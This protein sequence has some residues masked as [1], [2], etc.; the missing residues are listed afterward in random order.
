MYEIKRM[1]FH[2]GIRIHFSI[3]KVP[4]TRMTTKS[5]HENQSEFN[6]KPEFSYAGKETKNQSPYFRF[7]F[8]FALLDLDY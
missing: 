6:R 8:F 4:T 2:S 3:E 7:F 1:T 5:A